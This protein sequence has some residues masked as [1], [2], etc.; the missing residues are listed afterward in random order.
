VAARPAKLS[1]FVSDIGSSQ[2]IDVTDQGPA[3]LMVRD[4]IEIAHPRQA[5]NRFTTYQ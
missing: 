3:E 1:S 2:G 5:E 4:Y